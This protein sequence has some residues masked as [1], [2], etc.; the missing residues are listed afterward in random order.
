MDGNHHA[1]VS[2]QSLLVTL[3]L[4]E[5]VLTARL[6]GPSVGSREATI[7]GDSIT[8]A[9]A[10]AR[11]VVRTLVFDL[12]EVRSLSSLGLGMCLVVRDHAQ[13]RG[14]Q[15]ALMGVRPELTSL[16]RTIRI[17]RL[18]RIISDL[19]ELHEAA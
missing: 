12:A 10:R 18:C 14:I 13:R 6:S 2:T 5:G 11:G 4:N 15:T 1:G 16:L 8:A 19:D 3:E 9:L 7:I 17:D